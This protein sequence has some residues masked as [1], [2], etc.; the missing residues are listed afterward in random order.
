MR[1]PAPADSRPDPI[2][3]SI[4]PLV[5]MVFLLLLFFLLAGTLAP[6]DPIAVAPPE[7]TSAVEGPPAS[8]RVLL[9]AEGRIA[10]EGQVLDL[11]RLDEA[12]APRLAEGARSVWI[13]A[14]AAAETGE[15]LALIAR[16]RALGLG[17]LALVARREARVRPEAAGAD[18]IA[19]PDPPE[20]PR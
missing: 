20:Q 2:D 7:S 4:G 17:E 12:V 1:L 13:E 5:D 15:V 6:Q 11:A 9:D 3:R 16:L 14:D 8:L 18:A 19:A 10:F